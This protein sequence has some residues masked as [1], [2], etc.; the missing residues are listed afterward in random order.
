MFCRRKTFYGRD[1]ALAFAVRTRGPEH[2]TVMSDKALGTDPVSSQLPQQP[3]RD[4]TRQPS[5]PVRPGAPPP[6]FQDQWRLRQRDISA[7]HNQPRES[8][9]IEQH[10][11]PA[12]HVELEAAGTHKPAR[13]K[14]PAPNAQRSASEAVATKVNTSAVPFPIS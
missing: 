10:N 13:S 6:D 1:D 3:A 4:F 2:L 5:H 7:E 14:Y 11:V 9:Q 8:Y 12:S